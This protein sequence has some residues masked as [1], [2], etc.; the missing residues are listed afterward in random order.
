M[1]KGIARA[2]VDHASTHTH[3]Y[4]KTTHISPTYLSSGNATVFV[5]G[6]PGVVV[7]DLLSC[8][9]IAIEGSSTVFINGKG[10]HRLGDKCD[11]HA[12]QFSPSYCE[13]ASSTVFC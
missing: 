2:N 10:V 12:S 8:G 9:E 11:S 1:S 4:T 7:G 5:N 6:N 3:T 13:S